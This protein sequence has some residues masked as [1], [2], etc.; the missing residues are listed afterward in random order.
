MTPVGFFN[1]G[2]LIASDGPCPTGGTQSLTCRQVLNE[3]WREAVKTDTRLRLGGSKNEGRN[4][5][6]GEKSN[7]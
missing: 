2:D 3:K 5:M 7:G 4:L 6:S 1:H